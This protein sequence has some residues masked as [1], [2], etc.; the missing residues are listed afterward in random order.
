M[1]L[2]INLPQYP[3]KTRQAD[4][5][6]QVFDS[7]RK[8]YVALTPEEWVRQHFINYLTEYKGYP[9]GLISVELPVTINSMQQRA[10]I[11]VFNR[12]GLPL[13]VVECKS[14]SVKITNETYAQAARYNLS[15]QAPL[16]V[17]T[18]G[19]NHF[20]S[21]IDL[22]NRSFNSIQEIPEYEVAL[23]IASSC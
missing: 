16:L 17:V 7:L 10:D 18:N 20:C 9:A 23:R 15:L 21:Q 1:Q 22:A 11:V 14:P 6:L 4:G 12:S 13:M 2:P 3:I 19:L 8:R 5:Q